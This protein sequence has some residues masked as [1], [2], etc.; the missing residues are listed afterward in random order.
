[1]KKREQMRVANQM[2]YVPGGNSMTKRQKKPD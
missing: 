2:R 1:M